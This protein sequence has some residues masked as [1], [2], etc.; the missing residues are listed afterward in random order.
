MV[1]GVLSLNKLRTVL[2]NLTIVGKKS[3]L[4]GGRVVEIGRTGML[5]GVTEQSKFILALKCV[6]LGLLGGTQKP[7][8]RSLRVVSAKEQLARDA[9]STL[10]G[11]R[12]VPDAVPVMLAVKNIQSSEDTAANEELRWSDCLVLFV[13]K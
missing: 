8:T 13:E 3:A 1:D 11:R 6:Q 4:H 7:A 10:L 12:P 9:L 5:H 2:S